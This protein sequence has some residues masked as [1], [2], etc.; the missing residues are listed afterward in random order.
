MPADAFINCRVSSDIKARVRA[1]AQRQGVTE[2]AI[3]KQLLEVVLQNAPAGEQ[4]PAASLE[5]VNRNARVHVRLRPEDWK[6][7]KDR[8]ETRRMP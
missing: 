2:S 4:P 1:L 3:I 8:A 6:L 7:L 5:P